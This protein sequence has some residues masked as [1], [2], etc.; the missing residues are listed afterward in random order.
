MSQD[1]NKKPGRPK[2]PLIFYPFIML[3]PIL[4]VIIMSHAPFE[5]QVDV[6]KEKERVATLFNRKARLPYIRK[7]A[8]KGELALRERAPG[9]PVT[10]REIK[11]VTLVVDDFP[12]LTPMAKRFSNT[13]TVE[14]LLPIYKEA[15]ALA[16][17]EINENSAEAMAEAK[18]EAKAELNDK[19]DTIER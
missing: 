7:D 2:I 4:T 9:E 19:L 18:A 6:D 12:E 15:Y 3:G 13:L 14:T 16:D 1:S 10:A 5:K 11:W 8:I 17:K